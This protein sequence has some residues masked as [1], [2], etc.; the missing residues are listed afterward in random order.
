MKNIVDRLGNALRYCKS[1][2]VRPAAYSDKTI[3]VRRKEVRK[4]RLKYPEREKARQMAK[5]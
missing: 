1:D 4:H 2:R 5:Y 3:I